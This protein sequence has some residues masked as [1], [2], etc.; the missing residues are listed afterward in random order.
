LA[1]PGTGPD[2]DP[3]AYD[4]HA[5]YR[6]QFAPKPPRAVLRSFLRVLLSI[7]LAV[8][9]TWVVHKL[10]YPGRNILVIFTAGFAGLVGLIGG[11]FGYS[12][13]NDG[14]D[15]EQREWSPL[16]AI[17]AAIIVFGFAIP[18]SVE[19][20]QEKRERQARTDEREAAI[21]AHEEA[22]TRQQDGAVARLRRRGRFAAPG[23]VPPKFEV[24]DSGVSVKLTYRGDISMPI[25]LRRVLPDSN[26]P[27]GW[28]GCVLWTD[29]NYDEGRFDSH[30]IDPG[31]TLIFTMYGQCI[32]EFR[33]APLEY[34]V[35]EP[36]M[37]G[38]AGD[39]TWWSE[40][41]FA[42]AERRESETPGTVAASTV[43]TAQSSQDVAEVNA[44]APEAEPPVSKPAASGDVILCR[45]AS[46]GIQ[47]TQAY[48]PS[49]TTRVESPRRD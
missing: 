44:H 29:G 21:R 3:S 37:A 15:G 22:Q 18:L 24:R 16:D 4:G 25:A 14:A 32:E 6:E 1:T 8:T 35:G 36:T 49:G 47:F 43:A 40:S 13:L 26:S 10:L 2:E 41:A 30:I 33:G 46:G 7:G 17:A 9:I 39:L 12:W 11:A 27:G 42:S 23:I 28:R 19:R 48:C 38:E 5:N 31:M 34:R 45:D 20:A